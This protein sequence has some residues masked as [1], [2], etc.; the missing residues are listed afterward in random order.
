MGVG[1]GEVCIPGGRCHSV[2]GSWAVPSLSA[3]DNFQPWL[4]PGLDQR[5]SS[6]QGEVTG[7]RTQEPGRGRHWSAER[8]PEWASR[9]TDRQ[10]DR[11]MQGEEEEGDDHGLGSP[12]IQVPLHLGSPGWGSVPCTPKIFVRDTQGSECG[13]NIAFCKSDHVYISCIFYLFAFFS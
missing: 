11:Q 5:W 6:V 2:L 8:R 9:K 12:V 10:T 3:V 7:S 1:W 13:M 4:S